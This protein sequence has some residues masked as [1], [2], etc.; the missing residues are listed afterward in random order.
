M[1]W[2]AFAIEDTN[3]KQGTIFLVARGNVVRRKDSAPLLRSSK[4]FYLPN[5]M[6]QISASS[7]FSPILSLE[8]KKC[9]LLF[10][11]RRRRRRRSQ[12]RS[13]LCLG[14]NKTRELE[15][16]IY[17]PKLIILH[18][19]SLAFAF[20][21]QLVTIVS[22]LILGMSLRLLNKLFGGGGEAATA[23]ENLAT[24][25]TM[26]RWSDTCFDVTTPKLN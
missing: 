24:L 16:Q 17:R 7:F 8:K 14:K 5:S 2:R 21:G 4:S 6:F 10:S 3:K 1:V 15:F 25:V 26:V 20:A 11:E 13:R 23:G 9:L 12:L 22:F 19:T 18:Q